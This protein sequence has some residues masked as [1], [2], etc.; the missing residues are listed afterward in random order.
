MTTTSND[1]QK[2]LMSMY[3][4]KGML[5]AKGDDKAS[6]AILRDFSD[7]YDKIV[8]SEITRNPVLKV[9]KKT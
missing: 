5:L 2:L 9:L 4:T 7:Q 8:A 6:R 1:G 3:V